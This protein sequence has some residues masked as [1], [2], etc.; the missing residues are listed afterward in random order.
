MTMQTVSLSSLEPSRDN[1]RKAMDRK[2]KICR[3]K[4][5]LE[6]V[7]GVC[8]LGAGIDFLRAPVGAEADARVS[9]ACPESARLVRLPVNSVHYTPLSR[10]R[11]RATLVNLVLLGLRVPELLS[12]LL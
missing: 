7:G 10:L 3:A 4:N 6:Y 1:P 9:S 8:S 5:E 12:S 11:V 2:T